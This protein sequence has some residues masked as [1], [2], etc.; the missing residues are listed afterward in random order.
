MERLVLQPIAGEGIRPPGAQPLDT[1]QH[2]LAPQ[3]HPVIPS[4]L[5]ERR[6][7]VPDQLDPGAERRLEQAG[8]HGGDAVPAQGVEICRESARRIEPALGIGS[9]ELGLENL[10]P[11]L[12]LPED[13][14]PPLLIVIVKTGEDDA[15]GL[16]RIERRDD[17][18]SEILPMAHLDDV[19]GSG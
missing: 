5:L 8:I 19:P 9:M 7:L 10:R 14:Q 13:L 3:R 16:G 18:L 11:Q 12:N 17:L 2:V 15:R 6:E 1:R 4:A